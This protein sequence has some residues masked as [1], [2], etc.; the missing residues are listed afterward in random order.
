MKGD[1]PFDGRASWKEGSLQYSE[2][3]VSDHLLVLFRVFFFDFYPVCLFFVEVRTFG[4]CSVDLHLVDIYPVGVRAV[5]FRIVLN[6]FLQIEHLHVLNHRFKL[7][8]IS[9][10]NSLVA[11]HIYEL[12]RDI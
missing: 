11:S 8:M 4:Y 2:S 1:T 5:D 7:V 6:D 9:K 12:V 10:L 3:A